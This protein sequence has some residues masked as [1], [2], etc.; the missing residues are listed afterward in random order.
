MAIS[1]CGW[2]AS[3][4]SKA[5]LRSSNRHGTTDQQ[6][7]SGF[8]ERIAVPNPKDVVVFG[9]DVDHI[10]PRGDCPATVFIVVPELP[11]RVQAIQIGSSNSRISRMRNLKTQGND[12]E[13]FTPYANLLLGSLR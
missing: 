11:C 8:F 5:L 6:G 2:N 4:N 1:G 13:D 10:D 3:S 7:I 12:E 9:V